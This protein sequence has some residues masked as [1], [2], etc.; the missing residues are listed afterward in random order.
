M[1][2]EYYMD[3]SDTIRKEMQS[4][5]NLSQGIFENGVEE[6]SKALRLLKKEDCDTVE[7]LMGRGISKNTAEKVIEDMLALA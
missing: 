2:D 4:M 7:K 1:E 6:Y 3:V 5:C